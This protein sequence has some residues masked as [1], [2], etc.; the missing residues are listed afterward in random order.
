MTVRELIAILSTQNQDLQVLVEDCEWGLSEIDQEGCG[1][2]YPA[3]VCS[4]YRLNAVMLR[5]IYNANVNKG[6]GTEAIVIGDFQDLPGYY[7]L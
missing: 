4:V 2:A 6:F 7:K 1:D 5:E 3:L